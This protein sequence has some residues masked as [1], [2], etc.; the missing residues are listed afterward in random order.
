MATYVN[1]TAHGRSFTLGGSGTGAD[2]A[3]AL[4]SAGAKGFLSLNAEDALPQSAIEARG[5]AVERVVLEVPYGL[6]FD[7]A[8]AVV[9]ALEAL[10][11]PVVIQCSTQTR[12]GAALALF[13]GH[14][15]RWSPAETI[16]WAGTAGLKFVS[17]SQ[18]L[19]N[20]VTAGLLALAAGAPLRLAPAQADAASHGV[21]ILRQLFEPV[22][23]TFTYLLGDPVTREAVLIDP[24]VEKAERDAQLARELGL[25][26][27]Y[28][29]NTHVHADHVSG[30]NKLKGYIRGM[31]SVLSAAAKAAAEVCVCDGDRLAFGGRHLTVVATPG[32]TDGCISLVLDDGSAV[33]TGDALF[34]RG[35][36]R[37]DFQQGSSERLHHSVH[38]LFAQLR[39]E[40]VVYPGHDYQ[41]HTKSTIGEEKA[42]NPRLGA[43]RTLQDFV[44][45][46]A[47]L[48]LPP[49]KQLEVAVPAN[50]YD[51]VPMEARE[52]ATIPAMC[53]RCQRH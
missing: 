3:A 8:L 46:M 52:G 48:K 17:V 5:V 50:M 31:Q 12:A 30:T 28:G 43:G 47:D 45:I 35:C 26:V 16:A 19:R 11:G 18:P 20:W 33:F 53:L 21:L 22:S 23:C 51:G 41:G 10:P 14:Q 36:G 32:H 25:V 29:I 4:A 6:T 27:K 34:V 13:L 15:Q 1:V 7:T 49:P 40:C 44:Q 24:V 39:D 42:Y 38:K 2:L 9:A 37:T